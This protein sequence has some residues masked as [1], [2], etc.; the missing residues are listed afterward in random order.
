MKKVIFSF[1]IVAAGLLVASCG[2]KSVTNG[3]DGKDSA[4]VAADAAPT[5]YK[6]FEFTKFSVCV[7]EEFKTSYD[8]NSDNARF[9]SDKML[10]HDDG[11]EYSS[12]AT[13]DV[14]FLESGGTPSQIKE[15]AQ[16]MKLSQEAT[17]ETCDEP[18]IDGNTIL[19][20]H[21]HTNDSGEKLITWRWWI[22]SD[23]GKNINGNIAYPE[24]ES[25]FYDGVAQNIVKN[26]KIK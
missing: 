5:G 25:K 9:D 2:N 11:Q 13:I 24:K 18:I 23:S 20:R 8:A 7:P 17:G 26:I 3:A 12:S 15:T 1:A 10:K 19:M 6:S 4:T 22:V 21:Y 14:G 16:T